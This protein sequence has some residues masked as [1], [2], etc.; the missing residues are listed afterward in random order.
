MIY[1]VNYTYAAPNGALRSGAHLTEATD[2]DNAKTIVREQLAGKLRFLN[3][4][5]AT[6]YKP[7]QHELNLT[8]NKKK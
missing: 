7:D 2:P 1:R 4:T 6:E 5:N 3:V 8:A